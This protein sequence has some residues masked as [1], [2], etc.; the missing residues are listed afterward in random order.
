M[1]KTE[2]DV[3]WMGSSRK[4]IREFPEEVRVVFGVAI[5]FAQLG[6]KHPQATPMK[7]HKG[8]GVLEVIEDYN[9]DTY[10]CMYTVRYGNKIYI[11]HAFQKKAKKGIATPKGDIEVIKSRLREVKKLEGVKS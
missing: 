2:K 5:Y 10:R 4:D 3:L 9:K 7:G 6:G 11:L 8:A 1:A